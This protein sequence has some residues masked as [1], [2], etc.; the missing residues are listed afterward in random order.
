MSCVCIW[1]YLKMVRWCIR[2]MH[3]TLVCEVIRH[4]LSQ[5]WQNLKKRRQIG[6]PQ[7]PLSLSL[8]LSFFSSSNFISFSKQKLTFR[9]RRKSSQKL[10]KRRT[11]VWGGGGL[12]RFRKASFKKKKNQLHVN[13]VRSAPLGPAANRLEVDRAAQGL[14][15]E[16]V[17]RTSPSNAY[18]ESR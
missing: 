11:C 3:L 17:R 18:K 10:A 14:R 15:C 5:V 16:R 9:G 1:S 7:S 4:R 2:L 13:Y 6:G 8:P 12:D